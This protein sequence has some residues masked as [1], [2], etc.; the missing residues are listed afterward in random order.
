MHALAAAL[1]VALGNVGKTV[2][3]RRAADL[4]DETAGAAAGALVEEIA[5]GNVD[6]LVITASN[7]VY[8]APVDFKLGKLLERVP[9]SIYHGLYED[10]TAAACGT[11]RPGGA[12]LESWGDVRAVDGTVSIV[13]P[14]IAPLWGGVHGGRGA[15]GVRGRGRRRQRTSCC[16]SSGRR[17]GKAPRR[18]RRRLGALAGRR[19]RAGHRGGGRDRG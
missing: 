7:P 5:S 17:S 1:N 9:N 6:T 10:E 16:A 18:L 8:G 12:P 13:Q 19:H 3:Y 11:V 14:L 2:D 4:D 15:R